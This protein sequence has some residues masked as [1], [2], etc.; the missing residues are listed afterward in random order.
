MR[1]DEAIYA[2]MER[3]GSSQSSSNAAGRFMIAG[4]API[5]LG[6]ACE[7][8]IQELS[9]RAWTHT[10]RNRRKTLQKT[11][12]HNAVGDSDVFDFLIDFI[13]QRPAE[14]TPPP[15]PGPAIH[16]SQTAPVGHRAFEGGYPQQQTAS[17]SAS[18]AGEL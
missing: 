9:L 17:R 5:L 4:E 15:A 1:S 18:G 8:M 10:E 11:D 2:E 12:I 6:K 14:Q 16:H 3:D 7:L 13:P